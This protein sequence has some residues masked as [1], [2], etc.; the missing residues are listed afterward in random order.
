M[1]VVDTFQHCAYTKQAD[2][3]YPENCDHKWAE[4]WQ[5]YMIGVDWSGMDDLMVTGWQ[6]KQHIF[7]DPFYYVEYGLASLGAFQ[8]WRN[9][10]KDQKGG[11]AA[12]RRGMALGGT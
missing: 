1:A 12:Y 9:A 4:L 7:E 10:L 6:R 2:A 5:R 8:V 11:V 3:A